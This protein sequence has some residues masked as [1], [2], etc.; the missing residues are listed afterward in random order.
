MNRIAIFLTTC[1]LSYAQDAHKI[2]LIN[3]ERVNITSGYHVVFSKGTNQLSLHGAKEQV[4][5]VIIE[6]ENGVLTI[7]HDTPEQSGWFSGWFK[8]K[9]NLPKDY[10][11][12][13]HISLDHLDSL[14]LY[15]NSSAVMKDDLKLEKI[16]L[17]G[18]TTLDIR[19]TIKPRILDVTLKGAALLAAK[20]LNTSELSVEIGGASRALFSDVHAYRYGRFDIHGGSA[21]EASM[22][23]GPKLQL[24]C[25]GGSSYRV[26][27]LQTDDFFIQLHG[28][29]DANIKKINTKRLAISANGSSSLKIR[30]GQAYEKHVN[31]TGVASVHI[32]TVS[33]AR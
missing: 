18:A 11:L 13:I 8:K 27:T 6:Q 29:S 26:N 5:D 7:R 14:Y 28:A 10:N 16:A 9:N 33:T 25:S 2:P 20:S 17:S 1:V 4:E 31:K 30:S 15:G 22:I 19:T 32:D 23:Q 21:L 24:E 3:I 12:A